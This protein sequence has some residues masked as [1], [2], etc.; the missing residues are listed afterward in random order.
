MGYGA[1]L[2][3]QNK[4][5]A[6]QE[7]KDLLGDMPIDKVASGGSWM[8]K[9]ISSPLAMGKAHSMAPKMESPMEKEL[10]GKQ[11]SLPEGLK[12]AI[13]ASP[14]EMHGAMHMGKGA[15]AKMYGGKKGDDSKS[16]KDYESPAKMYGGKKGDDSKSRKDYK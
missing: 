1:P 8:S 3:N 7:K 10:V 6:A 12:K 5:Y 4:G 15:P 16:K 13:E 2:K 11:N 14:A 9:H